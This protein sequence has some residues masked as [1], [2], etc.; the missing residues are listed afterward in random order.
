MATGNRLVLE[1]GDANDNSIFFTF[2]Y[3]N[4]AA[5][6]Q[7]VRAV[8]NA[9]IANGSIFSYPPVSIKSAKIVTTSESTFN[10]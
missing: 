6:V 8:M 1:F 10:I 4:T 7:D 5:T 3:A 9:F 2:N